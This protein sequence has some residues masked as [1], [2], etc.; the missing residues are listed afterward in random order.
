MNYLAHLRLA[1]AQPLLRLGNLL[2]DFVRGV[3]LGTLPAA[4]RQGIAQHRAI[5]RFTDA[6]PVFR[7]SRARLDAPFRRFSGVLVDVFYDHFLALGWDRHGDGRSLAE[8]VAAI[9]G[10]LDAHQELLPPRLREALPRMR[11]QDWL[12]SY[13]D[14]AAIDRTLARMARRLRHANPLATGGEQ[15][16]RHHAAL[17]CDFDQFFPQLQAHVRSVIHA[18]S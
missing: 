8:F 5:D 1:P 6:H 3:D 7:Q 4:V 17:R 15:L 14:L 11:Q 13:G 12:G 2:G 9:H 18:A 10:E 16:R